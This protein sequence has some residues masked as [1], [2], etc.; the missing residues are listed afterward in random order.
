LE[1]EGL[2]DIAT[3]DVNEGLDNP[4]GL[5]RVLIVFRD[6]DEWIEGSSLCPST[7]EAMGRC[8]E[9]PSICD[10]ELDDVL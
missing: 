1:Y 3:K 9:D 10:E 4:L 2:C 8:M 5:E 7:V 6:M